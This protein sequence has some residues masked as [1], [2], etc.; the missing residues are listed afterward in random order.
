M[1]SSAIAVSTRTRP[2]RGAPGSILLLAAPVAVLLAGA[3]AEWLDFRALRAPLLL[4]MGFAVLATAY[5]IAGPGGGWRPFLTAVVTGI[6]TWAAAQCVYSVIHVASG[7]QFHA[8]RLGPQWSQVL[9]L[10][11]AHGLLLGA[12][13]GVAA[14]LMLQVPALRTRMAGRT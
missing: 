7:Q 8:T 1:S 5:A 11:A 2:S 4:M 13:T 3:S 10:V 12:P 14:G 6:G 9:A